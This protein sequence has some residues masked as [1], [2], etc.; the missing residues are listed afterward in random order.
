VPTTVHIPEALLQ[1]VDARAKALGTSRNRVVLA[2]LEHELGSRTRW[3][4]ELV[5][6]LAEPPPEEVTLASRELE[7]VIDEGRGSRKKAPPL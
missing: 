3:P 7:R 2:A 4:P 6:M 5:A 1:R